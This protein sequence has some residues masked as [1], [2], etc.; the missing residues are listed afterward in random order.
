MASWMQGELA[1]DLTGMSI[2]E[3]DEAAATGVI[4]AKYV[5][6]MLMVDPTALLPAATKKKAATKKAA[7]KTAASNELP[8]RRDQ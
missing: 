7:K 8:G 4:P 1:A 6:W 3:I 5:G 2:A